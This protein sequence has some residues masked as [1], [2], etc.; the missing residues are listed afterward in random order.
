[1]ECHRHRAVPL[2]FFLLRNCANADDCDHCVVTAKPKK[3]DFYED[4][5]DEVEIESAADPDVNTYS[6]CEL[7][8]SS[9]VQS[10]FIHGSIFADPF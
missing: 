9:P 3:R 6:S 5:A 2:S 1:L 7:T 8:K 4:V 10:T